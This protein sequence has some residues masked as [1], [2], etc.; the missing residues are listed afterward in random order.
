MMVVEGMLLVSHTAISHITVHFALFGLATCGNPPLCSLNHGLWDVN[1]DAIT[2]SSVP[3]YLAQC[4]NLVLVFAITSVFN[5]LVAKSKS[6]FSQ[7]ILNKDF[8]QNMLGFMSK[9]QFYSIQF[10]I[11]NFPNR[12]LD[13]TSCLHS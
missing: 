13:G 5:L 2:Y 7:E 9:H 12:P 3:G 6:L 10:S 4:V 8:S 1:Q 11:F